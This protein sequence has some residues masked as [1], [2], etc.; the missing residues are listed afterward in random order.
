MILLERDQDAASRSIRPSIVL[1][2]ELPQRARAAAIREV[3]GPIGQANQDG[4]QALVA[5]AQRRSRIPP[6]I[7]DDD[8][9]VLEDLR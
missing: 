6:D 4:R 3:Y 8:S 1:A 7:P 5:E 9:I 2:R